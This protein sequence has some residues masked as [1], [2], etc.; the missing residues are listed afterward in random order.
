MRHRAIPCRLVRA[1]AAL[2]ALWA[3]AVLMA[4]SGSGDPLAEPS[5]CA[6]R[7]EE[8]LRSG[9][10]DERVQRVQKQLIRGLDALIASASRTSQA[11]KSS[12]LKKPGDPLKPLAAGL[13][14]RPLKPA[15]ES[16]LPGG[17]WRYGPLAAPPE[18]PG[19]WLP[20]LPPEQR[21]KIADA[22]RTGRL[23]SRY[24]ELLREYNLRLAEG[25]GTG[26]D[27]PSG[28]PPAH[29]GSTRPLAADGAPA[30]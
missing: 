30:G 25:R 18:L 8:L 17:T 12:A 27:G 20:Q 26:A 5:R 4:V 24:I 21:R 1:V 9:V 22:F 13:T 3:G 29:E 2:A 28:A 16:V 6:A 10:T 11:G 7:A 23:P 15:E 14:G 19:G